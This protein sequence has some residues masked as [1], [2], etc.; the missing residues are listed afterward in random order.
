MVLYAAVKGIERIITDHLGT[1]EDIELGNARKDQYNW[2][3]GQYGKAM[4]ALGG[5]Q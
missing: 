1:D 4:Q 5:A 2:M 3:V